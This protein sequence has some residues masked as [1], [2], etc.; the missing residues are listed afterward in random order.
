MN[1]ESK[2]LIKIK[3]FLIVK[4]YV[5]QNNNQNEKKMYLIFI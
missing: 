3:I 2:H 5:N 1:H 4:Y